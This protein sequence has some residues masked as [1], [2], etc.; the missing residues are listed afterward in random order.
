MPATKVLKSPPQRA[1]SAELEAIKTPRNTAKGDKAAKRVLSMRIPFE[2]TRSWHGK[3]FY[4]AYVERR[5]RGIR[6]KT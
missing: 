1:A 5:L 4:A 6:F 3:P 2:L